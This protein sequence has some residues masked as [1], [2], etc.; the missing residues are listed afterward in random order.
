MRPLIGIT[1]SVNYQ[2][3]ET[4]NQP[5]VMLPATYPK[6]VKDAGGIP[7]LLSECDDVDELLDCLDGLVISGGRDINPNLYNQVVHEK[8]LNFSDEQDEWEISLIKGAIERGIPLLCICRGHQLLCVIR[9]GE[10]FQDLPTTKGYEEHGATGGQWSQHVVELEP[11]S[12]ISK[13][14]GNEVIG[15]S[16][17]HQG[18]SD[19]GDLKVVGRTS[20]GL[21]EAVEL[22]DYKFL[23]STQWHPEMLSQDA[24]FE[25]LIQAS[26]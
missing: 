2:D 7:L 10:L 26:M 20:D 8:T 1:T 15:N 11:D 17:H 23:I 19:A 25:G 9:G 18:V 14:L 5:V 24:I 12:L 3:Y 13:L 16:G 21:I 4:S 6:A 22:E